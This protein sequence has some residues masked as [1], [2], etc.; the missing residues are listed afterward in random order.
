M[1]KFQFILLLFSTI[2]CFAQTKTDTL[3]GKIPSHGKV[4]PE[5]IL[6]FSN[7]YQLRVP[8]ILDMNESYELKLAYFPKQIPDFDSYFSNYYVPKLNL[9]DNLYNQYPINNENWINTSRTLSNYYGLGGMTILS[10]SYSTKIGNFGVVTGGIYASKY[11]I[12]NN[13]VN[14]MGVNG[15]MKFILND[16]ISINAFGQYPIN[17]NKTGM[18]PYLFTMYPNTYYGGS[19]EFK[20]TDKWGLNVGA[21]REFDVFTRKW[22]TNTF[23]VPVFYSH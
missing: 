16:R 9:T 18:F 10:G 22:V 15:N 6:P 2:A 14:N 7:S 21:E 19:L 5:Y 4:F 20:V 1:K 8:P 12:Y 17:E 11:N 23:I 3:E 13:F